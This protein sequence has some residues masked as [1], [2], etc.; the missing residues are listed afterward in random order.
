MCSQ[1]ALA[2]ALEYDDL[3]QTEHITA[4]DRHSIEWVEY[5]M[6][7]PSPEE[8][9]T[10]KKRRAESPNVLEV[11]RQLS[12]AQTQVAQLQQ[13]LTETADKRTAYLEY[14]KT[15]VKDIT[16]EEW[17]EFHRMSVDLEFK[18]RRN[19]RQRQQQSVVN[20]MPLLWIT[21]LISITRW[22]CSF[23]IP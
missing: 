6:A 21:F 17:D 15:I 20:V 2:N 18:W 12:T 7:V 11:T 5:P 10:K 1:A 4:M 14:M 3:E 19:A 13:Q 9:P 23:C 22:I 8:G 16:E